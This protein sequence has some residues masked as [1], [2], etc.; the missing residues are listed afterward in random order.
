MA[1]DTDQINQVILE[2]LPIEGCMEMDACNYSSEANVD[3][4]S[5]IPSG[6]MDVEACNFNADAQCEGEA[7]DY[8]CCPG[9]GCCGPGTTWDPLLQTCVAETPSPETAENC[10]LFNLQELSVGYLQLAE[11]NAAQDTLIVTQQAAID[12]LNALLNSCTGND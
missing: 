6:C 11:Q 9:P 3:D 2:A 1:L 12:S 8:S 4:G 7:C 5:C 10:T